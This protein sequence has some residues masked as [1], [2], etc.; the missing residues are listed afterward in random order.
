MELHQTNLPT[1]LDYDGKSFV[2][3]TPEE[4]LAIAKIIRS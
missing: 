4:M 2:K 3:W 1:N